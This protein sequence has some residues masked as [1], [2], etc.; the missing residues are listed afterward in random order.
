[1]TDYV[2]VEGTE[3]CPGCTSY[4][5]AD[6]R[7]HA[8]GQHVAGCKGWEADVLN[9]MQTSEWLR[10]Q[11]ADDRAAIAEG[12]KTHGCKHPFEPGQEE[13]WRAFHHLSLANRAGL[14][15]LVEEQKQELADEGA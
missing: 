4:L 7:M 6:E 10:K 12:C 2:R 13:Q 1:M 15:A 8:Y 9:R 11:Q 5:G 14:L 3:G